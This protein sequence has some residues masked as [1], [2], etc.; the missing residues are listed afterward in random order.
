ESASESQ[1]LFGDLH[2]HTHY[3]ADAHLQAV[4]IRH[5][6]GAS[7][8][9]DACD[10]ARF[11]SQLDFWSINDHAESLTPD[12]WRETVEAVQQCNEVAGDPSNPDL[13]SF[14]GWEWSHQSFTGPESHY[15]HK[16]VVLRDY[17]PD[18]IPARP[19]ASVSGPPWLFLAIG[20][21]AP[22]FGNAD[23]EDWADFHRYTRDVLSVPDCSVGVSVRDLPPDCR[24]S[25]GNPAELFAKLRDWGLPAVVIP[26]GL[27]WGTTNP[28]HARLDNQ[29]AQH[30]TVL[31]P[32]LEVY[33]GH[34]N[35]EVFRDFR[36]PQPDEDDRF[37]CPT[38]GEDMELC[39]ERASRIVGQRCDDPSSE[40]CARRL[41]RAV[42]DVA[43]F[44]GTAG[45]PTL[46]V[47]EA[48]PAAWGEC[49]Q[50][51]NAFL[52]AFDYRPRQSAQYALALGRDLDGTTD[53]RFRLGFIGSSDSHRSR[54]GTGYREFA[55]ELMT[56]GVQYPIPEGVEDE[57]SRSYYYTGGLAAV[58]TKGRDRGAIFDA[59]R[60]R[61]VYG[62][63]GDRILLWFD[64]IAEDEAR[65]TMGSELS[66]GV[67]PRFEVRA[68]GAFE[69]KPGCPDFAAQAL[70]RDRLESLCRGECYHPSD[71]RKAIERIEVVR[72]RPQRSADEAIRPLIEDP[73]RT[74]ACPAEGQGCIVSFEDPDFVR[75]GR[76]SVY[77]V[78]AIQKPSLAVNGDPLRCE[79]D[80]KG[81]C[82]RGRPC[83]RDEN[84][85][86]EDCLAEVGERAWSSPIFVDPS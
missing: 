57:R 49:G 17:E 54:P 69:Q 29:L 44:E 3:S 34:G 30:D 67:T 12:H 70:T 78:R 26:H 6:E 76:E 14:L 73:W 81:A 79:R 75:D 37:D 66:L 58:H 36:R 80:D 53:A 71:T 15:G 42:G 31:Q 32:L 43:A 11:C 16:N 68:L 8:P 38:G 9:A 74:L 60:K 5:R 2:V 72:I 83:G 84:G 39:C 82:T 22:L 24:E 48:D 52:P 64:L 46:P 55:R 65:F 77:Y 41:E 59:L 61:Q 1:V 47:S 85:L 62:T 23:L 4:R 10:F 40:A 25:A 19:I 13:V 51:Q 28:A 27:S 20:A 56:D 21:V 18:R 7:P 63:S 45:N 35:S 86:P 50:L 33:S